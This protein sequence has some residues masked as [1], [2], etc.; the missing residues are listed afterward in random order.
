MLISKSNSFLKTRG[1]EKVFDQLFHDHKLKEYKNRLI[2]EEES[3]KK[4]VEKK[5]NKVKFDDF[6]H[7]NEEF[8]NKVQKKQQLIA[9]TSKNY[10]L[11]S[12]KKMFVPETCTTPK[13]AKHKKYF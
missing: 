5:A 3:S 7:R 11:N 13:S 9:K 6:L 1:K 8:M 2:I 10:D 4:K 12:G